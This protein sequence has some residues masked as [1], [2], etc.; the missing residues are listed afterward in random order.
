MKFF[1]Y[2]IFC[3][4]LFLHQSFIFT[5]VAKGQSW[6][7][8]EVQSFSEA[9]KTAGVSDESISLLMRVISY[10]Q[11]QKVTSFFQDLEVG[12]QPSENT[13]ADTFFDYVLNNQDIDI[14]VIMGNDWVD[15]IIEGTQNWTAF[16]AE[17]FIAF[18]ESEEIELHSILVILKAT[19]YLH[20]LKTGPITFIL[21]EEIA[22]APEEAVQTHQRTEAVA[23]QAETA[24]DVFIS[25]ARQQF[26]K[27]L[28][29]KGKFLEEEAFENAFR[30]RMG[31]KGEW[32]TKIAEA[33]TSTSQMDD[34][35]C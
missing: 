1:P 33:T 28:E 2:L 32:E 23:S 24:S 30:K 13:A 16:E 21:E 31:K 9:L 35:R 10:P 26:R 25:F 20:A 29:E 15:S 34:Q 8:V 7:E 5:Q 18:L 27:E 6:S 22:L 11:I 4:F 19:D 14:E 17:R 12:D 3:F